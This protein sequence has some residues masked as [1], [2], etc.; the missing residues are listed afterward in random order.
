MGHPL[1]NR[2]QDLEK[3]SKGGSHVSILGSC[4]SKSIKKS[5]KWKPLTFCW[6]LLI[7]SH[8][9]LK[10]HIFPHHSSSIYFLIW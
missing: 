4:V 5:V 10:G 8:K 6:L 2:K 9:L 7:L 1:I 3:V